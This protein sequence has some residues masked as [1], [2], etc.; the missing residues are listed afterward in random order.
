MAKALILHA[1]CGAGH[2]RAAEAILAAAREAGTADKVVVRDVLDLA[3]VAFR[4]S[5]GGG[6]VRLVRHAPWL[7]GGLYA[8]TDRPGPG[9]ALRR[10]L[11][12]IDRT[13]LGARLRRL[14][15]DESPEVVI[16]THFLPLAV[17]ADAPP[18]DGP[19]GKAWPPLTCVVTDY[20]AHALWVSPGVDRYAVASE[21]AGRD[22]VNR[23]IDPSRINLTGIPVDPAFAWIARRRRG[24]ESGPMRRLLILGGGCGIGPMRDLLPVLDTFYDKL[25]I[26]ISAGDN[27]RLAA[28]LTRTAARLK[29]H[30][31]IIG[32]VASV[33]SLF[34][35]ADLVLTKPG[36]LTVTET[37]VADLPLLLLPG[38]PGQEEENTRLLVEAGAARSAATPLGV[39]QQIDILRR[40]PIAH[41][42]MRAAQA[43]LARHDAGERILELALGRPNSAVAGMA[44]GAGRE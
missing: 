16:T 19:G 18:A 25:E 10:A 37:M 2:R 22:L 1:S 17:L 15:Q 38:I 14:I 40:D 24:T 28:D 27:R 8:I 3:P 5:Y 13:A 32:M 43:R 35:E 39:V 42:R 26:T 4:R 30:V 12:M 41:Q 36:G 20:R 6:Y 11:R 33:E 44:A 9:A 23:G 31:R 34:A 7:W 21:A 29:S